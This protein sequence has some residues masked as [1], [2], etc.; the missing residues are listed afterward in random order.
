ML[1]GPG[2]AAVRPEHE[3]VEAALC[4]QVVERRAYRLFHNITVQPLDV[5][6]VNLQ[7]IDTMN[8]MNILGIILNISNIDYKTSGF[9]REM[10]HFQRKS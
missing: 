3:G 1:H 9:C 4:A 2:L 6:T 5:Y 10:R 8:T 7:G